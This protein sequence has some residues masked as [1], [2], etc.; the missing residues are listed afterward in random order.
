MSEATI[1]ITA[2]FTAEPVHLPL[3]SWMRALNYSHALK[4]APYGQVLQS[5]LDT[6]T[7]LTTTPEGCNVVLLRLE[8]WAQAEPSRLSERAREFC[9]VAI[10]FSDRSNCPLLVCF[11]P[12]DPEL[13]NS[14]ADII[15]EVQQEI[16]EKLFGRPGLYILTTTELLETYPVENYFDGIANR[17][18]H[19]PYSPEFYTS[20]GTMLARRIDAI[21]RK[22]LKVVVVDCDNT[23][24]NGVCGELGPQGVCVEDGHRELQRRL[25]QLRE[26]GML[27]ALCSKNRESDVWDVFQQ[28]DS[29][30]LQ[31][32]QFAATQIN[33]NSKSSN[34]CSLA[35][36]LGVSTDS[37]V[38]LDDN[39]VEIA[40]VQANCPAAVAIQVPESSAITSFLD[41]V[42]AFDLADVTDDDRNRS[43]RYQVETRRQADRQESHSMRHFLENLELHVCFQEVDENNLDRIA[44]LTQRTNQFNSSLAHRTCA[45]LRHILGDPG[46]LAIAVEVSDKFGDYGLVGFIHCWRK[47]QSLCV[48]SLILSCRAL[49]RGVEHHML[50]HVGRM[51]QQ[52]RLSEIHVPFVQG[53]R[54]QPTADFLKSFGESFSCVGEQGKEYRYPVSLICEIDPLTCENLKNSTPE[55]PGSVSAR[56]EG[57]R[58]NARMF[59]R[60]AS[61]YRTVDQILERLAKEAAPRPDLGTPYEPPAND[62]ESELLDICSRTLNI[63][64]VGP[65]DL[66]HDLGATSLQLVQIHSQVVQRLKSQLAITD[67][68]TLPTVR[69]IANRL[70]EP[71]QTPQRIEAQVRSAERSPSNGDIAVVGM[72]GRFPGAD[73]VSQFWDNLING[74]NCIVEIPDDELNL[75]ADSPLRTHPNLVRKAASVRDADKFDAKFFGIFPKEAQ[76]MDPQHRLMLETCWHALEDA[77]YCPDA[78]DCSVGV[79]AGCYMNTYTLA[80]LTSNPDLL[81]S[82]ANSFHGGDLLTELGNDK[83]YLATRISFLLD[84]HGPAMT[85]QTACSTSLVAIIQACQAL[86]L[87]QCEMALAGGSTLKLPQQRGYL[88]S[89]GGMVS[90]D[91]VCRAF[92]ADARGTVFG[93]GVAAVLL[94]RVEDAVADGDDI[95]GVIKGW[96]INNDGRSKM[97]YTAPSVDGQSKAV[98]MAHQR[99]GFSADTIT[100]I[101]A[102][103][104]GTSLG[105]PIEIDALTRAFRQSTSRNQFCAIGSVKSN[106]G[107]LDVAAGVTGLIKNCLA[108]RHGVIPPSLNFDRPN[109]N[110][111]FKN[112]PFFVVTE[113]HEWKIGVTPRRAGLSSF[114]VGGTNAHVVIE[115]PPVVQ[116]P[117]TSSIPQLLTLSARSQSALEQMTLELAEFFQKQPDVHLADVAYTL[118]VGRKKQ[119]YSRVVVAKDAT[120]ALERLSNPTSNSVFT[121][122]QVRHGV[123]VAFLFPGQGA[124][125][126]NMALGLYESNAV[127]RAEFNQCCELLRPELGFDLK[128]KLF[129]NEN[130]ETI[131]T[132]N[133]TMIAQPAIFAVSYAMAKCFENLGIVPCQMIGHSVGE[134]VAACLAGVFSLPDALKL[135]AFRSMSMQRLPPGNMMAVRMTETEITEATSG[136]EAEIA[137]INGPNLC[138]VAGPTDAIESL[139]QELEADEIVCRPLHTSHAFHSAMMAPAIEPVADILRGMNLSKPTVPIISSITGQLLS[140]AQ[141]TDPLYWAQHAR[142]T[143]RFTDSVEQLLKQTDCVLLEVGPG[144][145][146]ST[147]ARQHPV[148][149]KERVVLSSSPHA[150][151][152]ECSFS[153]L[154]LTLGRVWQAGAKVDWQG[155]SRGQDR[156][157]VHLPTYPFE[158]QRHWF[159]ES[160]DSGGT[161]PDNNLTTK[162]VT[163]STEPIGEV[164]RTIESSNEQEDLVTE[165]AHNDVTRM[166]IQQQLRVMK[167][168]LEAW[169]R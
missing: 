142:E 31:R 137:A 20:L 47:T 50:R 30:L 56:V 23:L 104:T 140:D 111:D 33:W 19:I 4:F 115:E 84:L 155:L 126:V 78:V 82:L 1:A 98:L 167:Q 152:S 127:F 25:I 158:R 28:N 114:G 117:P 52:E 81:S 85:V 141:A 94:K 108:L 149:Q 112:S 163:D 48:G 100:Y 147:L 80:S 129:T 122:H 87:G 91:G 61:D 146:L 86:E 116:P 151:R 164:Q 70:R 130:E 83:D 75:P 145:T 37:F 131:K 159:S 21:C 166:V 15:N 124:Q 8:D 89:E 105:D 73:N 135:I 29:M 24:W 121:H 74:L 35:D 39:P 17:T 107:H 125:H 3:S 92:D 148:C 27:L 144:Q 168:Q 12:N 51:A 162:L 109:P 120:E 93:E 90:P 59:G 95:Y 62:L 34:L 2:T 77:G 13:D 118:Q 11:C 22:P 67:F 63:Q 153:H 134:F 68:Y 57:F 156:R 46:Q 106:I 42:W 138:V 69:D 88:Y 54:N 103:G 41:H 7:A 44:Q 45:E 49:G 143:V 99:A 18:A 96:G 97:G 161:V 64:Q 40:E 132:L 119:N 66:L 72:A 10:S 9:D 58:A 123:P 139:K 5:L 16:M 165:S 6:K 36:M 101:E 76:V 128:E 102:H 133:Q 55:D 154:L 169:N 136:K 65:T 113:P 43:E 150:N 38:F 53:D 14:V 26:K 79:F 32:E 110:I 160:D 157:R 60:I 71:S